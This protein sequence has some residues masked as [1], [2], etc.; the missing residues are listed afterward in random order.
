MVRA[1]PS[2][3]YESYPAISLPMPTRLDANLS[4]VIAAR[5]TARDLSPRSLSMEDLSTLLF[6]AYGE[7][8]DETASG[9]P[10]RFRVIPSGGAMYPLEIYVHATR[11]DG[12]K[13]GIY[14]YAPTGH[15]LHSLVEGD[16]TRRLSAALVQGRLA[17]ESS[18]LVFVTAIIERAEFKYG[19][20]AYRFALI[21]AGHLA[22]NFVLAAHAIGGGA[23]TV[24]GY[25]DREVDSI[26]GLD[27]LRQSTIYILAFGGR[28]GADWVGL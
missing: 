12:L 7:T 13:N 28:G 5:A 14:H 3:P 25:F 6:C 21:E 11:I 17:L 10:R 27:G 20:R 18:L 1:W 23:V 9:F 22:Q 2:F 19:E 8:R 15:L 16:S 4:D 24:G 26:L